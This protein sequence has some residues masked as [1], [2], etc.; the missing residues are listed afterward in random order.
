MHF[1]E[2]CTTNN[3]LFLYRVDALKDSTLTEEGVSSFL[4]S[5]FTFVEN[6]GVNNYP[7]TNDMT[8]Q[9]FYVHLCDFLDTSGSAYEGSI[10]WES[11]FTCSN[12]ATA[13]IHALTFGYR[14]RY[15]DITNQI[16]LIDYMHS[17]TDIVDADTSLGTTR[18]VF[19]YS[20]DYSSVV[21]LDN[22]T[23]DVLRNTLLAVLCIFLVTLLLLS[24][25]LASALVLGCVMLTILDTAGFMYWWGL[26]IDAV[27]SLLLTVRTRI[28]KRTY[29]V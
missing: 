7:D 22:L 11:N 28:F 21:T 23:E 14:H 1:I 19:A 8:K 9:D 12:P 17:V 15:I 2:T 16:D 24:N 25:L 10:K 26:T 6:K 13:K 29:S 5:F 20:A 18:K 4:P 3:F 27:S